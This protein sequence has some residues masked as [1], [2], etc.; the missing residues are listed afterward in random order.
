M[1]HSPY[2]G[3]VAHSRIKEVL[4]LGSKRDLSSGID[5][6]DVAIAIAAIENMHGVKLNLELSRAGVLG[7][8]GLTVVAIAHR[9]FPS[10]GVQLHS[11]SRRVRYPNDQSRTLE[12]CLLKLVYEIDRDCGSF[13]T[14]EPLPAA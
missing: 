10:S 9:V 13:W 7:E 12:G 4:P 5:V 6:V 8:A 2:H 14:Q 3:G 11:V 1:S